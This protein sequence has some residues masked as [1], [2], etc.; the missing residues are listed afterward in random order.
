[1]A[2]TVGGVVRLGGPLSPD[3][4]P[5]NAF[6]IT[7][8]GKMASIALKT[9]YKHCFYIFFASVLFYVVVTCLALSGNVK[10]VHET[11]IPHTI[12]LIS[13]ITSFYFHSILGICVSSHKCVCYYQQ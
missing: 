10:L 3:T 12:H 6:I 4:L 11:L 2:K 7:V 9:N 5:S 8:E 13:A 1:M